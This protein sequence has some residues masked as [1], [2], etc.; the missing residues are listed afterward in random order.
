MPS[1]PEILDGLRR[2]ANQAI[3]VA[4][5]WH[6]LAL[7]ALVALVVGWRPSRRTAGA[8]LA[9]PVASAAVVAFAYGNPF[10]GTLLALL[11][12]VF[13]ALGSR[14]GGERAGSAS[15]AATAA[16]V[17]MIAL[18]WL[19]PH[20]LEGPSP[21]VYLVAAP[22]GVV[23]CTTLSL[24]IGF[25]LLAGGLRSRAWALALAAAGLFYG[26]VGVARLG[27][28][29][30]VGLA[31]GA[32]ALVVVA[33]RPAARHRAT[34]AERAVTLP[35]DEIVPRPTTGYTLAA[36]IAAPPSVV[37]PWLVQMGQGRGGFYTHEWVE[38]LLG[39]DIHNADAIVPE[40]QR[41]AAGDRIRLTPDPYLGH[42]GQ[43]LTVDQVAAPSALVL[44]QVMPNGA[45]GSWA[46]V[47][48][49]TAEGSTR[50]IFRRRANRPSLFDRIARPGYHYMDRGMLDGIRARAE[51]R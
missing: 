6:A 47:L 42:P 44:R 17:V 34:A 45:T 11:A 43:Y 39:A 18:G 38:K 25:A 9:A 5:L 21:L 23:P 35:G 16:G 31:A 32:A 49:A 27:V 15:M 36:S 33:L 4:A 40:W 1:P 12:L 2:A 22:T 19:Y 14:L 46:Y 28:G 30:D 51:Q 8:L 20:F 10:N 37:W 29:L 26:V 50:L 13:V 24:V 7:V 48:R 3:W 41:I